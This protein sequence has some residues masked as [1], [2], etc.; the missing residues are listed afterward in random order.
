MPNDPHPPPRPESVFEIDS[1]EQFK[2]LGHPART[3]LLLA[4]GHES[5]TISQLARQLT[6][7][8]GSVAHHLSVLA[9][10]GIVE[11]GETRQVRGGT[12]VY[13]Q[14]TTHR[15]AVTGP[16]ETA[17][18]RLLMGSVAAEVGEVAAPLALTVR[19]LH[20][21][22]PAAAEVAEQLLAAVDET[23]EAA[24]DTPRYRLVVA[25]YEAPAPADT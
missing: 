21:S 20:L 22:A 18:A 12:E 23:Q 8:K 11:V 13:W 7:A 15:I 3:R 4:L 9:K 16:A 14:R 10:A 25:V 1:T 17:H 2:A 6:M 5:A 24:P 19:T